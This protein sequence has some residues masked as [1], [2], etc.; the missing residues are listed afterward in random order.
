MKKKVFVFVLCTLLF[1]GVLGA[2]KLTPYRT[3]GTC[4]KIDSTNPVYIMGEPYNNGYRVERGSGNYNYS[5]T[6]LYNLKNNYRSLTCTIGPSDNV[7]IGK[8]LTF[9]FYVDNE[10]IATY[11]CVG[12]GFPE[13]IEVPLNYGRQLKLYVSGKNAIISNM[14]FK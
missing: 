2:A 11:K 10:K 13:D 8:N 7:E 5:F 1:M 14:N 12:G 3:E 9:E 6:Q 4:D